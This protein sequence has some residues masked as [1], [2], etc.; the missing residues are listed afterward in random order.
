MAKKMEIIGVA[1][2]ITDTVAEKTLFD[3]P[4][5]FVYYDVKSL[6]DDSMIKI[7]DINTNGFDKGICST[8]SFDFADAITSLNQPFT[9]ASIKTF[10]RQ[11]L[12]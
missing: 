2:V 9:V 1:L 6:E 3:A 7:S 4:A 5:S 12:G 11:N 8:I 10:F